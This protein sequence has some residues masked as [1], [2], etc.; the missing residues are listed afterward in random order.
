M[1]SQRAGSNLMVRNELALY[2]VLFSDNPGSRYPFEVII[3]ILHM[4]ENDAY[5]FVLG[6]VAKEHSF[7]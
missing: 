2:K 3:W 1:S 4:T 7:V 5:T 6:Y